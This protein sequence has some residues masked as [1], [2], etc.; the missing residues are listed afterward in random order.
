MISVLNSTRTFLQS[1]DGSTAVEY[2]VMVAL[3]ITTCI[4][5]IASLGGTSG[6]LWTDSLGTIEDEFAASQSASGS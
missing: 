2:A 5:A 3:I 1:D 4:G 6:S